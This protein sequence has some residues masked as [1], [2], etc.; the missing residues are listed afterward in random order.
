MS[1]VVLTNT[2]FQL[3]SLDL[4]NIKMSSVPFIKHDW[5]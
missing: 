3:E 5:K 4:E 2:S 1:I